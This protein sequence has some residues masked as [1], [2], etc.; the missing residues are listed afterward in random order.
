MNYEDL[1]NIPAEQALLGAI[2][3]NEDAMAR[4]EPTLTAECFAHD[5]HAKVYAA[6]LKMKGEGIRP[7]PVTLKNHFAEIDNPYL[8]AMAANSVSLTDVAGYSKLVVDLHQRRRLNEGLNELINMPA[9]TPIGDIAASLAEHAHSVTTQTNGVK[10]RSSKEIARLVYDDMMQ[11][12]EPFKTGISRLDDAMGGGIYAGRAYGFAGRK[13]TG[14]TIMAATLSY[15]LNMSGV[16]HMFICAEMGAREIHQRMLARAVAKYPSAFRKGNLR[17]NGF[18]GELVQAIRNMPDNIIYCDAPGITFDRLKLVVSSAVAKFGIKGFILDYWQLVGGK[19]PKESEV[20][21]M[22]QVAQWMAD[23]CKQYDIW[24]ISTAQINQDGNTR[25][26]EGIRLAFDQVYQIHRNNE[27]DDNSPD[28]WLEMMDTR[29][30][31]WAD[32]GS[33]DRAGIVLNE[34]GV[35]FE[36][37]MITY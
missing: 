17:P 37:A 35:F 16:K 3:M 8:A 13:K 5:L 7:T 14:K 22:G 26:G 15:N 9:S 23:I 32:V 12:K 19:S 25:G 2:L 29:Y 27:I 34:K 31:S 30:T 33:K 4:I 18:E 24:V 20:Y 6:I 10:I 21:H 36:E 28:F 11:N 1:C